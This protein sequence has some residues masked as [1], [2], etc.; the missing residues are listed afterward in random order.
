MVR[1]YVDPGDLRREWLAVPSSLTDYSCVVERD[2]RVV[3]MGFLDIVDGDASRATPP[4][5]MVSSATSLIPG[6]Q[7][8][9]SGPCLSARSCA[10]P[11]TG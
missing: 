5:R 3:A 7:G 9:E 2:G 6:S 1:T 8:R 10:R 11:S 4:A